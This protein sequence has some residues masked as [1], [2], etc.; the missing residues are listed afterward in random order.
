VHTLSKSTPHPVDAH[1][2]ARIRLR[3]KMLGASQSQLGQALGLTFQQLQ[4]YERGSNRISA[5]RLHDLAV[6]LD[7]PVAWFF[8]GLA[9]PGADHRNIQQLAQLEAF[10]SSSD[11]ADLAAALPRLPSRQRRQVLALVHSLVGVEAWP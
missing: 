7:T 6:H 1:V 2:G 9:E 4:K 3:R 8:E 10:L 5:S 11:G